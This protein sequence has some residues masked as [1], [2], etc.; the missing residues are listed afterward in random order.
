MNR[1]KQREHIFKIIFSVAFDM[2]DDFKEHIQLYFDH[3]DEVNEEAKNSIESKVNSIITHIDKI[4]ECINENTKNWTTSR[5]AKVDVTI[6]RLA[7]YEMKY[8]DEVPDT[9]AINEAIELAKKFGGDNS[10]SFVNGVLANIMK[11]L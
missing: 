5:M 11:S 6:I 4:D 10:S 3:I 9:V 8:D 2:Q 1:R 7:V